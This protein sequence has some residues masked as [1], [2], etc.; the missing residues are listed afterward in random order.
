M[1]RTSRRDALRYLGAGALL[2][3][4]G[5]SHPLAARVSAM[6]RA[7]PS[8]RFSLSRLV[9]RELVDGILLSIE[10]SWTCGFA[11]AGGGILVDGHDLACKVTA[12]AALAGLAEMER[13]RKD[14]GPFPALL[15]D[16]GRIRAPVDEARV[17]PAQAV[18]LALAAMR[19]G[20]PDLRDAA[21]KR[22]LLMQLV[23]AAGQSFSVIPEDLFFPDIEPSSLSR[24]IEISPGLTGR[25][26]LAV[27]TA[28]NP[29]TGLLE[30]RERK[31][32]TRIADDVRSAREVWSLMQA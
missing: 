11:A 29:V 28:A 24:E 19:T 31:L 1:D 30:R 23:A 14:T 26:D 25:I 20:K 18:D 16:R 8:G 7:A 27:T 17:D 4:A 5:F 12:P 32:A 15:D 22:Q 9:E 2:A 10:R 6:E 3:T 13:R 21:A